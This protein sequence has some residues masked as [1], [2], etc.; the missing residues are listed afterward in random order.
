[1]TGEEVTDTPRTEDAAIADQ[2]TLPAIDALGIW[3]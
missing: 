1:M 2:E 3:I